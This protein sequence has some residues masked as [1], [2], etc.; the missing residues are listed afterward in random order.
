MKKKKKMNSDDFVQLN[1]VIYELMHTVKKRDENI[2]SIFI[3]EVSLDA[4]EATLDNSEDMQMKKSMKNNDTVE[5]TEN[6][7]TILSM[8]NNNTVKSINYDDFMNMTSESFTHM[9]TDQLNSIELVD[10]SE[11]FVLALINSFN[12]SSS[13]KNEFELNDNQLMCELESMS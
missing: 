3:V 8:K 7:D 10:L 12:F 2:L 5:L 4:V 9:I 11:S 1:D 6:N 13:M